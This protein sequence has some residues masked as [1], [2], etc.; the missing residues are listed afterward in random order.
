MRRLLALLITSTVA[1]P[2]AAGPRARELGI[3]FDGAPGRYDAITD[4]PG[5]EVGETTIVS[6]EKAE[7]VRTGVTVIWPQG[8][9]NGFVPAAW[10]SFNGNGEMTG[11][12]WV[13]ESGAL[14]G[15]VAL[16]NTYSVG[17]VR[18]AIIDYGKK[19]FP[20]KAVDGSDDAFGLPVVAETWDWL[21]NDTYAF[22]VKKEHVFA[23]LDGAKGGPVAEGSVG[24]GT[25]M[26]CFE[27]KCGTGTA[28]RRFMLF[29]K[30]YTLGVL[31]QANFGARDDLLVKG[32]PVGREMKDLMPVEFPGAKKRDGSIIIVIATDAPL[33]PHQLKRVAKRA[34]VGVG[35]TGGVGR[36]SSG[37]IY[38]AFSTAVPEAGQDGLERWKALPTGD[39]SINA[40]FYATIQ[41]SEEAV[42]NALVAGRTMEGYLGSK[43][44]G[45]PLD[46]LAALLKARGQLK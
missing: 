44:Y 8:K 16:T 10:F 45:I 35:M 12:A 21:L 6:G 24:G 13:D 25:G 30:E 46:R 36:N 20:G 38:L 9:V 39:D 4:V 33:L 2:A 18:D 17:L 19:R 15:P 3:P 32:V 14:W 7:A 37:D 41:A 5:V 26:T 11:T 40:L 29:G 43:A 42:L 28:S 34:A 1:L 22:A 23:A 31:V 27:F